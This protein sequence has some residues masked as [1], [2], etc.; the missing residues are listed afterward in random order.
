MADRESEDIEIN[1]NTELSHDEDSSSTVALKAEEAGADPGGASGELLQR[2]LSRIEDLEAQVADSHPLSPVHDECTRHTL[3]DKMRF[4]SNKHTEQACK[5]L[6]DLLKSTNISKGDSNWSTWEGHFGSIVDVLDLRHWVYKGLPYPLS[7]QDLLMTYA[8]DDAETFEKQVVPNLYRSV[9]G[10]LFIQNHDLDG[11]E[12]MHEEEKRRFDSSMM[13][14][15]SILVSC[16]SNANLKGILDK[17]GASIRKDVPKMFQN[18]KEHFTMKTGSSITQKFLSICSIAHHDKSD[19]NSMR[20]IG[21]LRENKRAL[22]GQGIFCP[23]I[24]YVSILL[25]TLDPDSAIKDRLG[26]IV[27]EKGDNVEL[28]SMIGYCQTWFR[29]K[30]IQTRNDKT[31]GSLK[32]GKGLKTLPTNKL[33]VSEEKEFR[34]CTRQGI[35]YACFTAG[36]KDQIY[37]DCVKHYKKK[38]EQKA[39]ETKGKVKSKKAKVLGSYGDVDDSIS[40][41]IEDDFSDDESVPD[42]V[43]DSSDKEEA[44]NS[45]GYHTSTTFGSTSGTSNG[46]H[47]GTTFGS[48]SGTT[49]GYHTDTTFGSYQPTR[50]ARHRSDMDMNV[51]KCFELLDEATKAVAGI[52]EEIDLTEHGEVLKVNSVTKNEDFD[53]FLI[54]SGAACSTIPN[55]DSLTKIQRLRKILNLEY[56]DGSTG[57]QIDRQGSLFLN[58]HELRTLVSPDLKEGL[59]STSQMD[60]E[61][62]ATTVQTDG[63][64]ITFVPNERQEQ[65]L[66]LLLE[67]MDPA[68]VIADAKLNKDGLYEVKFKRDKT[69]TL[70]VTVFPRVAANS[71]TQAV[72][73]LHASLGHMPQTSLVALAKEAIEEQSNSSMVLNWPSAMTPEVISSHFPTCRACACANQK[74]LPFLS[75]RSYE[76]SKFKRTS[77]VER[78]GQLGQVDMWGPYPAGRLG[79]THIFSIIDAYSQYVVSLPCV[80]KSGEIPKLL[81]T[82]LSIFQSLGVFFEKIVGDSA[83]NTGSCRHVLHTAYGRRQGVQF[84]LA[85]P[86]EHETCGIIERFFSTAQRRAA[87]NALAFLENDDHLLR[88]LGLDAMI[89]AMNSINW[90]PRRK[91]DLRGNPASVIGISPLNFHETLLLPFGIPAIA[92]QKRR[93][94]KLHGHGSDCIYLGPSENSLHRGGLFYSKVTNE[95]SVRR[96]HNH[97]VDRPF[98]DFIVN[99]GNVSTTFEETLE[100]DNDSQSIID[101]HDPSAPIVE[102]LRS[103]DEEVQTP[104]SD[105]DVEDSYEEVDSTMY[106]FEDV[107]TRSLPKKKRLL[108]KKL[109]NTNFLEFVNNEITYV[110]KVAGFS[111]VPGNDTLYLR[112]Y[113]A[114]LPK[115]S[116]PDSFE[117]TIPSKFLSWAIPEDSERAGSLSEGDPQASSEGEVE[118]SPRP[119]RSG[120]LTASTAKVP[121]KAAVLQHKRLLHVLHKHSPLRLTQKRKDGSIILVSR[122][123]AMEK[124]QSSITP[125]SMSKALAGP[126]SSHWKAARDAEHKSLEDNKTFRYIDRADV[127]PGVKILKSLYVLKL[128]LHADGSV[129]K[130]KVR[131]VARGDLQD[132]TTYSE[133]YA[134]TCQRKAVMLLLALANKR[135]WEIASGDISTAFLY[136]DLDDPIYMELPDGRVVQLLKSL[137]G[138]R[139]AAFKFKEHLHNS[140]T[141]IGFVQL[142]T[143]SSVYRITG[144]RNVILTCHVDDLLF[145]APNIDDIRWAYD[146]LSKS[147][148]MTFEEVANEY[149]GY[150]IARKRED[151]ILKLDQFGTVSKLLSAFPP[152]SFSKV[153]RTPYHRKTKNFTEVEEALLPELE[154]SMYQ[155]ITGSLLYLAICTRGDLLYAVHLLTRRMATP[156]VIDLQRA[157]KC[158]AYL[159][160]TAHRGVTFH[161]NDTEEIYGWADSSFNSGE[162]DRKNCYGYCFQLGK[163]SGMFVNACKRSTLIALSSTEAEYYCLAEA[164]REL[165]WIKAFLKEIEVEISIGKIFQ[166][167]TTTIAMAGVEGLSERSKH[168]DVKFHF[169][170]RLV[171]DK[172]VECQHIATDEMVADIFTKDLAD[173]S[174]EAHSES[175][176][177]QDE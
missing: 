97:W 14:V 22:E 131:L 32:S 63:R 152:Q 148:S 155:Q 80:N 60:K 154:K 146:Q 162:G 151:R 89:F 139:Q 145:I 42:L 165:M 149:L 82:A 159:L 11:V 120:R 58:G 56:A 70:S 26:L 83:F 4:K 38:S 3:E 144:K 147:Y 175:V 163:R 113:D 59:L 37:K 174:F 79:N 135:D 54:D 177:G 55:A 30:D 117:Y 173:T 16:M 17:D 61:L 171:K 128:A 112:Y 12:I 7:M 86:D 20:A 9:L 53:T 43:D 71:L 98:F 106:H 108:L 94:T 87:A 28:E 105:S 93:S 24:M 23:D 138:L 150:N 8:N 101:D 167:N 73:L 176:L 126:D 169:V 127:P 65:V 39:T 64:S 115:P 69:R 158:V 44:D 81:K 116:D 125:S 74:K 166:D 160:Q 157:R 33:S 19:R 129:K 18:L 114:S 143:D 40:V 31:L 36:S 168:I 52:S 141:R 34:E 156:R 68:N 124:V 85:I 50:V 75:V 27:N 142:Q 103:T 1:L 123:K 77:T 91:F 100:D 172:L 6:F 164:C 84:S 110:W 170:K 153:L 140:L 92:H 78:V 118:S 41:N 88:F 111:R 121:I 29:D 137:Y 57:T 122:A 95:V 25:G 109:S 104:A 47:T 136:G 76:A 45:N 96:S 35:C 62:N 13:Y 2:L 134:S 133:T 72:Y 5:T 66:N 15:Y 161:G 107:P 51:D 48:T 10:K 130:Y 99:N 119:R 46:Y 21:V 90:T 67:E 49:N 102:T 132:P